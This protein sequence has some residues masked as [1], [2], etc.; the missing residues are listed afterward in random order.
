M[1]D[2]RFVPHEFFTP[3]REHKLVE[4]ADSPQDTESPP[5]DSV[6]RAIVEVEQEGWESTLVERDGRS[7][8]N[9]LSSEPQNNLPDSGTPQA[10]I[11]NS[12]S[13]SA[14]ISRAYDNHTLTLTSYALI[15][16]PNP[17]VD[18]HM[19]TKIVE[20]HNICLPKKS[21]L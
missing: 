20:C 13:N 17:H 3:N 14:T 9:T 5:L 2:E 16:S 6:G 11:P 8:G 18:K 10:L 15:V 12:F 1:I 21:V 7:S 19:C 4:Y